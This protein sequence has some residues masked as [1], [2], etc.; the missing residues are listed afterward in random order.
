MSLKFDPDPDLIDPNWESALLSERDVAGQIP[1][2]FVSSSEV[3]VKAAC[4]DT[5]FDRRAAGKCLSNLIA[6]GFRR[7]VVDLYWSPERREWSFCPV[8]LPLNAHIVE[9]STTPAAGPA[10][11]ATA[12]ASSPTVTA[13]R[14]DSNS[15]LYHLGPYLCSNDIDISALIDVFLDYFK[16]T[17][18]QINVY[19]RYITFNLHVGASASAPDQPASEMS[20][21]D[22]PTSSERIST[23]L[24][25]RLVQFLYT[26]HQ[27]A[28]DRSNLNESWYQVDD[29]YKPIAEYFTTYS[30]SEGIQSTP[31]GWP[32]IKYI[33][34]AKEKRLLLQYG[35]V[36]SQLEG[37]SLIDKNQDIFPPNYMSAPVTVSYGK[38]GRPSHCFYDPEAEHVSQ[39]NA[40]WAISSNI[41]GSAG[42]NNSEGLDL[43]SDMVHNLTACGVTPSLNSTLFHSTADTTANLY[44]NISLSTSWA[45]A[46][47][48]PAGSTVADNIDEP[49]F[50]RCAVMDMSLNG[51]WRVA[52]C[53]D[54]RHAACR[55]GS[56]PFTW[57]L[58]PTV[59]DYSGAYSDACQDDTSLGVPRTG[60]ENTFLHRFLQNQ[61]T[62]LLDPSSDDPAMRE[63]WIDFNSLDIASCWVSGGPEAE[64]PYASDPQQL[65]RRTVLVAAVAG[66][67]I[68]VIAALTLFVKCNANRRNSRRRN[69]IMQGWEYEGVPS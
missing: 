24:D 47:G 42:A 5:V 10:A 60:L 23:L 64:C 25:A 51:R 48:Q 2:N 33:Q 46:I 55:V 26:P 20:G 36:D 27:L 69:R 3:V 31:D 41:P 68:C 8:R 12:D 66:I 38:E 44:K 7:L 11:T 19:T 37:Y 15:M 16:D 61:S 34:L 18:S 28:A 62:E 9:V 4:F 6:V 63:V 22:L 53:T 65:E 40:S 67:V 43:L 52:N 1:V 50:D 35:S 58:S 14:G 29:G 39:A 54:V 30:N 59:H 17:A 57:E 13:V 56:F 21:R 32:C 49:K 45:W